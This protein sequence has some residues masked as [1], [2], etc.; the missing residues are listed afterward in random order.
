MLHRDRPQCLQK[1]LYV[2]G[3]HF[4]LRC[5]LSLSPSFSLLFA[6]VRAAV[7]L[8]KTF[9]PKQNKQSYDAIPERT[10]AFSTLQKVRTKTEK[11][12][13]WFQW[14]RER[15]R[16][17][18]PCPYFTFYSSLLRCWHG[19][20]S[21]WREEIKTNAERVFRGFQPHPPSDAFIHFFVVGPP[22]SSSSWSSDWRPRKAIEG[23]QHWYSSDRQ[24][25]RRK[26][27][28][29]MMPRLLQRKSSWLDNSE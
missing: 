15:E 19:P 7:G 9:P 5:I 16:F 6:E 3:A 17:G 8:R 11:W 28:V 14:E 26:A 25:R 18:R 2:E 24:R 1:L 20:T 10:N 23:H 21:V 12:R 27:K 22:S 4:F 13:S 29:K